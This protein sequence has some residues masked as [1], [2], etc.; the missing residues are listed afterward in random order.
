MFRMQ[1]MGGSCERSTMFCSFFTIVKTS[2][3]TTLLKKAIQNLF[4][5][6]PPNFFQVLSSLPG[7]SF[8]SPERFFSA[9]VFSSPFLKNKKMPTVEELKKAID[10]FHAEIAPLNFKAEIVASSSG[11]VR[12]VIL[13]DGRA[14]LKFVFKVCGFECFSTCFISFSYWFGN[15]SEAWFIQTA[16][17]S[18]ISFILLF[19]P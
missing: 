3:R 14:G 1:N 8:F 9:L 16:V 19:E 10:D 2:P 12:T 4:Y 6:S 18:N 11:V 17:L 7:G 15:S 13:P 5:T